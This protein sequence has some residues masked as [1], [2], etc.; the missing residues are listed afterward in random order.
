MKVLDFGLAKVYLGDAPGIDLSQLPTVTA[1]DLQAGRIVGTPAYMSPEQARGQTTDKRTDIWA[2][3]CVLY[4]IL[5][6]RSAFAG[7]TVSDTIARILEREPDW[8]ALPATLPVNVRRLLRRCL[9]KD[10]GR[11]QRDIGDARIELDDISAPEV[12]SPV[13][14]GAT[15]HRGREYLGWAA[16][17]LAAVLAVALAIPALRYLRE[18][19]PPAPPETRV[20]IVTPATD[21][22]TDFA[23]SPDG[24]QIVFV[25]SGDGASRLWLRSLATTTAQPLAGTEGA[26]FPFW[27]PDSRAIGFF[28]GNALKR[29]DVVSGG[30]AAPQILAPAIAGRGGTWNADGVIVFA[31]SLA[32]LP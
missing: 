29:L 24:R 12:T 2:F 25:A 8:S 15:R 6:G 30:G 7:N 23:L 13:S 18:T 32:Q 4:E 16:A 20:E 10:L 1:T 5:T 31:P 19:P 21:W 28:A 22:P 26:T 17:T 3:A 11:R 27:S 9:E 14:A